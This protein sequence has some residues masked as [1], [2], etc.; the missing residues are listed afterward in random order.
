M[1]VIP[2]D[3]QRGE[4]AELP[5]V[6]KNGS[7]KHQE[8]RRS[9][10]RRASRTTLGTPK[11]RVQNDVGCNHNADHQHGVRGPSK[12]APAAIGAVRIT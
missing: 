6:G 8:R 9:W 5:E 4:L 12:L 2:Q 3:I 7:G 10:R 1:W 11:T